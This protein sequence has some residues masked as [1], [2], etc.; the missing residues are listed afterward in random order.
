MAE[1]CC[2]PP[3]PCLFA[4]I[5]KGLHTCARMLWRPLFPPV[6]PGPVFIPRHGSWEHRMHYISNQGWI[7]AS[8]GTLSHTLWRLRHTH[9][10][11]RPLLLCVR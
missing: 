2:T 4:H 3:P 9:M 6:A 10:L 11:I 5:M 8:G 1:A 7:V